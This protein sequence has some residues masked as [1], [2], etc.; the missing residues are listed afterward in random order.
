MHTGVAVL[1]DGDWFGAAVNLAARVAELARAG[2]VLLSAETKVHA[3]GAVLPGQLQARGRR[4]L[5]NIGEPVQ[6]F[7]LV[8]DGAE[9]QLPVD[10]VC[11]M[12]I[13][14]ALAAARIVRGGIEHHFCSSGCAEAFRQTPQ[15]YVGR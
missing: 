12:A 2:E 10:P 4:H 11:R 15:R 3:G 9:P 7:V 5:K 14:P 6:V 13:D 8:P 1:R